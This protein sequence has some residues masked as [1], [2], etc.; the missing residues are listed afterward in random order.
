MKFTLTEIF[1][2]II[3]AV[4]FVLA[5]FPILVYLDLLAFEDAASLFRDLTAT[6]F[7]G[8]MA[9]AYVLGVFLDA[10]GLPIDDLLSKVKIEGQIPHKKSSKKF[11]KKA[12]SDLF[13]YRTNT[14][15]HYYCFRNLLVFYPLSVPWLHVVFCHYS[16]LVFGV[17][18]IVYVA[19]FVGLYFS[20]KSHAAF[21]GQVTE[22]FD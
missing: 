17:F 15:N 1:C 8:I 21:Y 19:V 2:E 9:V 14:W 5:I 4:G 22:T 18:S 20:V 13:S 16:G 6:K 3:S 11:F 12:S 7:L 10:F